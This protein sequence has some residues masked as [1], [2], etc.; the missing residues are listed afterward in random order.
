[1]CKHV[2]IYLLFQT[3]KQ[4]QASK[5]QAKFCCVYLTFLTTTPNFCLFLLKESV[6]FAR[7]SLNN[8]SWCKRDFSPF[9]I[10][11]S[12][13]DYTCFLFYSILTLNILHME[14]ILY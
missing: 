13:F 3:S 9:V 7:C 6:V 12:K 11:G 10:N 2:N 4:S 14:N 5:V 8:N 1:M